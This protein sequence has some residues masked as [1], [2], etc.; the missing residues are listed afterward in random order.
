MVLAGV[1]SFFVLARQNALLIYRALRYLRLLI[2]R[3]SRYLRLL[4]YR[5]SRLL[6]VLRR[7]ELCGNLFAQIMRLVDGFKLITI[8]VHR[9]LLQNFAQFR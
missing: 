4:I 9:R 5:A 3:A 2:Y 7:P 8:L 1:F 6:N